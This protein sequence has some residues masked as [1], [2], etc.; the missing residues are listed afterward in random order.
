MRNSFP[1]WTVFLIALGAPLVLASFSALPFGI[2][3]PL[4]GFSMLLAFRLTQ[5]AWPAI[6][7]PLYGW[8]G[9]LSLL[10]LSSA[11]W[12]ITPEDSLERAVKVS[13]LLLCSLPVIDLA[14]ACPEQALTRV[15]LIFPLAALVISLCALSELLLDFPIYRAIKDIPANQNIWGS[16]LNKNIAVFVLMLPVALVMTHRS[17][18]HWLSFLLM[19]AA[20]ALVIVTESQAAQLALIV[21]PLAWFSL[22][23]LPVSA[24]P[25]VFALIALITVLMPWLSPIAFDMFAARLQETSELATR[26]SA[27]MRLENWDFISRKIMSNLWTGF[28]M[29]ATRSVTD[30][31][32]Q[33]LY[34]ATSTIMHPH[35]LALQIWIEFGLPGIVLIIGFLGFLLRRLLRLSRPERRLPFTLFCGAVVFLMISWSIWAAWLLGFLVYLAA[36][37]ILAVKTTP[38]PET[39]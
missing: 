18:R 34:F 27:S 10:G 5:G 33:R 1:L 19:L 2:L 28:G 8:I 14:R 29:D 17:A 11:F 26:A 21:I 24:I 39:S 16:I 4:T 36:L 22:F 32:S 12:S 9:A 3:V 38:A 6:D 37:M 31:E 7:W 20:I 23:I 15:R 25:A 35:N 13:A 30:F